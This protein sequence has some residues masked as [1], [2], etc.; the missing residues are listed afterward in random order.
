MPSH[1]VP[2]WVHMQSLYS[3]DSRFYYNSK[4]YSQKPWGYNSAILM[5]TEKVSPA[6]VEAFL[7]FYVGKMSQSDSTHA[8]NVIKKMRRQGKQPSTLI[9]CAIEA[10]VRV[11]ISPYFLLAMPLIH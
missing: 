5:Y 1:V 9:D 2:V 6:K 7:Y 4:D 10:C 8:L 11:V 3:E